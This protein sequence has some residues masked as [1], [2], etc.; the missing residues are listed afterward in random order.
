MQAPEAARQAIVKEYFD[1]PDMEFAEGG[2]LGGEIFRAM[3]EKR[4]GTEH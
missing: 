4:G 1:A 2:K 3:E